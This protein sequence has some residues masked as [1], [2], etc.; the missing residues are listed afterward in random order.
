MRID[1]KEIWAAALHVE[2][3]HSEDAPRFIAER[4]GALAIAGDIEGV[5]TWKAIATKLAQARAL[6]SKNKN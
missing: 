3:Q 5:A 2:R 4:I 1:D 6:A